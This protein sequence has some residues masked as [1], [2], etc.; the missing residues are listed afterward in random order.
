MQNFNSCPLH[1]R[2]KGESSYGLCPYCHDTVILHCFSHCDLGSPMICGNCA[3][4]IGD[5]TVGG[6]RHEKYG[7][8]FYCIGNV[9]AK[10]HTNCEHYT[11]REPNEPSYQD[12]VENRV[13]EL[14]GK[15]DSSPNSREKR[16][17]ARAEW[18]RAHN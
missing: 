8:C 17:Q 9:N 12:W 5:C 2:K 13:R 15:H 6:A 7:K 14:G 3:H 4:W 11:E 1:N 16:I 10:Y 18:A